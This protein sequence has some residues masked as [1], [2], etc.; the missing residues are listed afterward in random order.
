MTILHS[1]VVAKHYAEFIEDLQTALTAHL[2][3]ATEDSHQRA[4]FKTCTAA[5]ASLHAFAAGDKILMAAAGISRRCALL[6][7]IRQI[8]L[9]RV[10][11]RRTIV[12]VLWDAYFIDHPVEFGEFLKRGGKVIVDD[13]NTP[14]A[15]GGCAPTRK[16]FAYARER[17]HDEAVALNAVDKLYALFGALSAEVHA[18]HGVLHPEGSLALAFD[19]Y[20]GTIAARIEKE[21]R[22]VLAS[23]VT[24]SAAIKPGRLGQLD[25][26][27]RGWFDWL[28][29]GTVSE[30]ISSGTFGITRV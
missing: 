26:I 24:I 10:E 23:V 14:I 5:Y 18:G 21:L 1:S 3:A 19:S 29:G 7:S 8:S 13:P 15:S 30:A 25:A 2:S 28:V 27:S 11:L 4:I 20:D 9:I 16:F 17:F 22:S 12:C 6:A